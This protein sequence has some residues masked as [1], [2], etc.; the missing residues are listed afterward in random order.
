MKQNKWKTNLILPIMKKYSV[1][2]IVVA[3]VLTMGSC[4]NK[5]QSVP[6]DDGDS[7]EIA[8]ADQTIF[9]ISGKETTMN[10]L[11]IIT[12]TGDTLM[13]DISKAKENNQVFGGLQ[14]GDRMAVIPDDDK[15]E[16]VMVIN[17]TALLGSW[18][19]PNPLDGSDEVG[20]CIKE[21]GIAE[22]IE[23]PSVS[24][25]TWRLTRGQL[26]LVLVREDSSGEEE[27]Q[28]FDF[29]NVGPDSLVF[30]DSE[31]VYRYSRQKPKVEYGREIDLEE[32]SVDDFSM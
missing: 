27:T 21:G 18:V 8:N 19:M 17:Q 31:D 9:G 6:F 3:A 15:D 24:Y 20:I 22:S 13:I 5:T 16:A 2:L 23:M 25:R 1:L 28:L 14:A 12:D 29:L 32:S 30:R 26:E 11:Q 4:G 10:M 7:A